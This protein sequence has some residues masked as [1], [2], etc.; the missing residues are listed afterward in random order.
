MKIYTSYFANAKKIKDAAVLVG[1][2]AKPPQGFKDVNIHE[3]APTLSMMRQYKESYDENLFISLY[4]NNILKPL[5][6][7]RKNIV[8]FLER[9][10]AAANKQYVVL[11]C[12]EK[13][14]DFCHRH[15]VAEWLSEELGY[16]I[17]E[18]K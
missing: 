13:P 3:L 12:Y 4:K 9:L 7:E 5:E 6:Q 14:E 16:T 10:A 17:E 1:I 11:L 2:C 15:L 8:A 18:W